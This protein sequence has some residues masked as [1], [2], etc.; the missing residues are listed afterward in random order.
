MAIGLTIW[1]NIITTITITIAIDI[2]DVDAI[3]TTIV[4]LINTSTATTITSINIVIIINTII[5]IT[6]RHFA[7]TFPQNATSLRT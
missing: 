4:G 1:N 3:Y 7:C 2:N 5:V 6:I